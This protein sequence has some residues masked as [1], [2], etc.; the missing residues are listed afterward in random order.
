MPKPPSKSPTSNKTATAST[1]EGK[2]TRHLALLELKDADTYRI[3]CRENG[4]KTALW[5]DWQDRRDELLCAEKRKNEAKA[6]C[7]LKKRLDALGIRS[8]EEYLIWCKSNGF[9]IA[10]NKTIQQEHEERMARLRESSQ[11][12]LSSERKYRRKPEETLSALFQGDLSQAEFNSPLL[13]EIKLAADSFHHPASL[14]PNLHPQKDEKLLISDGDSLEIESNNKL[15]FLKLLIHLGSKSRLLSIDPAIAALGPQKGNSF[16]WALQTLANRSALW[17]RPLESWSPNSH[18][19]RRQFASLARHLLAK[20]D[21]PAVLDE[22]WFEGMT[23]KGF[24]HQN[25]FLH[26]GE[27]KNL[28]TAEMEMKLTKRAA[29][30]YPSAPKEFSIE[31]ALRWCQTLALSGDDRLARTLATTRLAELQKDED[32]WQS[33]VFFFINNPMLNPRQAGPLIDFIHNLKFVPTEVAKPDGSV[34][35]EIPEPNF[36]MKGRS[37]IALLSR[38]EEWH[39]D[40]AKE[41]RRPGREWES[42]GLNGIQMTKKEESTGI[43]SIWTLDELLSTKALIEEGKAMRHCVASYASSCARGSNSIW[44][45][46]IKEG[47]DGNPRRV[48]TVEADNLR[49]QVCQAR[50]R[51]NKR[52]GEK[53]ASPRLSFAPDIIKRWAAQEGLSIASHLF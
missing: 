38:M 11:M 7:K 27:G 10:M 33:V 40:L 31:A 4:F 9:P 37:G 46:K 28:R 53:R 2:L 17:I 50:G 3:W 8:E 1:P 20:Y 23:E 43:A 18:N 6:R 39:R 35:L 13:K 30:L 12:T 47:E 34:S 21:V 44:S 22:S 45:L 24:R 48:M 29:H 32:F 42:C 16:L 36:S 26:I 41:T 5:K 51:C 25:W 19:P 15:A 52:P 14:S 49:K